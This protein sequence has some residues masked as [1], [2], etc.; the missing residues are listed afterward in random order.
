MMGGAAPAQ[1]LAQAPARPARVILL[2]VSGNLA[3]KPSAEPLAE[4]DD[5]SEFQAP[6]PGL[7]FPVRTAPRC[8]R[9]NRRIGLNNKV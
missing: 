4:E 8:Q 6:V 3:R 2:P 7:A 9:R 1:A 5:W